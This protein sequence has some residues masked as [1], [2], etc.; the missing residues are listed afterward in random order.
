MWCSKLDVN[1]SV[2]SLVPWYGATSHEC[3]KTFSLVDTVCTN[4]PENLKDCELATPVVPYS[5]SDGT[6]P[7]VDRFLTIGSLLDCSDGD[8]NSV[9]CFEEGMLQAD[10]FSA[11][12]SL[13]SYGQ[14]KLGTTAS[15]HRV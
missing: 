2:N 11:L 12:D 7:C 6:S 5:V 8:T 1:L 9:M 14:I 4:I 10:R 15:R 3:D 13:R